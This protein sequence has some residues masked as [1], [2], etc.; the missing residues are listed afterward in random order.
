MLTWAF[1]VG[2]YSWIVKKEECIYAYFY[3]Y[4][5]NAIFTIPHPSVGFSLSKQMN[6]A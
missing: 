6:E 1:Y 5:S 4:N 2:L 3:N